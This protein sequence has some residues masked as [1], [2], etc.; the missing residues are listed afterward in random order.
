MRIRNSILALLSVTLLFAPALRAQLRNHDAYLGYS[1]LGNNTFYPNV[2]GQNG[3]N[4]ALHIHVM[5][6][7]GVEGDVARYGFGSSDSTPKTTTFL[8]GPRATVKAL[9]F[10]VFAHGLVG[11]Q[12]SGNSRGV[13][14][15]ESKATYA[16]GG[17]VDIPIFP[18]FAWR[19]EADRLSQFSNRTDGTHMRLNTGLVF[20]F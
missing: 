8:V 10:A 18:F 16:I 20:R 1:R 5:P 4:A 11:G 15:S 7:L 6:F 14:I 9:G 17:G 19:V 12:H 13:S 3:F 2:G